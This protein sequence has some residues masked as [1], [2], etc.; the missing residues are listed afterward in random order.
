MNLSILT[1]REL[2]DLEIETKRNISKYNNFQ[3]AKK[4]Q[5]N[6][7][8]GALGNRYFRWFDINHAEAITMSGQLTTRWII[9]R[10][11]KYINSLCKT[12][13]VDYV[14]AGDTDSV[15]LSLENLVDMVFEDQSD[16]KKIVAWL[17]K[18]CKQK[19]EPFIDKSYSDL[20]K[21]MNSFSQK[22]HMKRE[23][24]ADKAIWTAKK[25]YILNVW[26][27]EGVAYETAKL[28]MTGIEAVKSSTPQACRDALKSVFGLIM[29]KTEADL[30]TYVMN[31][32]EIFKTLPFQ[33]IASPRGVS[34][35][36]Q[37]VTRGTEM[38]IKGTPI[39]AKGSILYNRLIADMKLGGKYETVAN[40]D[41][42]KY[43]YLKSPN[44]YGT[45][46]IACPAELPP[47]FGLDRYIDYD[48]Q[49]EKAYL[50]PLSI[51]LNSIGW[52]AEKKSTLDSFFD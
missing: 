6:S 7:C 37:Y 13:S 49:F 35:L 47:E 29:N 17:D 46:V 34:N 30:Q 22:M 32:R 23:C 45:N 28:K 24:I 1:D 50:D 36:S 27:Q 48:L 44:P 16:T 10:L 3:M 5:L 40:G 11:N 31:F 33:E 42:I 41:K 12:D 19:I 43:C 38:F 51:V 14:V 9:S 8:Y 18:V 52:S 20:A 21:Y 4:I 2:L 39:N 26:N 25:R 15:Y